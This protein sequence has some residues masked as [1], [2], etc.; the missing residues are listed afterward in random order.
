MTVARR[1]R[2]DW[3]K[4][5]RRQAIL[6]AAEGLF[7]E[8]DGAL[9]SVAAVAAAAGLAKGTVYLYFRTKE[10]I[11]LGLLEWR[12]QD[13]IADMHRSV[14]EAADLMTPATLV[15]GVCR[16]VVAEPSVL[17]LASYAHSV[18]E[19]NIDE[20]RRVEFK[21]GLN[22]SLALLAADMHGRLPALSMAAASRLL[23][24][25]YAFIVGLWQMA[26]S[27]EEMRAALDKAGAHLLRL[28]F[29]SELR[30]GLLSLWRGGLAQPSQT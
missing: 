22:D 20:A 29:Q 14:A 25:S 11:F 8:A 27:S 9:P 12:L 15:E 2:Q 4:E 19:R 21:R 13:W 18:L 23:L 17:M 16:Y 3:Q 30:S 28:D 5:A 7:V 6:R 26:D 24:H 1:A 10:E